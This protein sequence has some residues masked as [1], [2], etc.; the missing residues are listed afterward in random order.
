MPRPVASH[1]YSVTMPASYR[2]IAPR[3]RGC[4]GWVLGAAVPDQQQ[5][6]KVVFVRD[7]WLESSAC[8]ILLRALSRS[9]PYRPPRLPHPPGVGCNAD[10]STRHLFRRI[11]TTPIVRGRGAGLA[12]D[13]CPSH[14]CSALECAARQR[15]RHINRHHDCDSS[16][17]TGRGRMSAR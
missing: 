9:Q 11:G 8:R 3:R 7:K 1:R 12:A 17:A 10:G 14:D 15:A 6:G 2:D 5:G 4:R 16:C 13:I